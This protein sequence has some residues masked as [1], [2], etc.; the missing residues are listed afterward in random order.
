MLMELALVCHSSQTGILS[1]MAL[2]YFQSLSYLEGLEA[3]LF[4]HKIR[5]MLDQFQTVNRDFRANKD[6][7]S[8]RLGCLFAEQNSRL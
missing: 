5:R 7:D 8:N 2:D 4:V 3:C 6:L 1:V